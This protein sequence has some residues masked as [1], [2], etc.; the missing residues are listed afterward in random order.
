MKIT[1]LV[2]AADGKGIFQVKNIINTALKELNVE[3]N[4]INLFFNQI[5][6]FD[7]IKSD[8]IR[9]V[10]NSIKDSQGVIIYTNSYFSMIGSLL[11]GFFEHMALAAYND[12][13][14]DKN[15]FIVVNG[16]NGSPIPAMNAISHVIN[17]LGGFDS[18]RLPLDEGFLS[19]L[20][21]EK[22][23]QLIAERS[24]EDFYR[25]LKQQ[26]KYYIPVEG[27]KQ[28]PFSGY[29]KEPAYKNQPV[30][31]EE[32]LWE[33]IEDSPKQVEI[34][35]APKEEP[36][37]TEEAV[38]AQTVPKKDKLLKEVKEDTGDAILHIINDDKFDEKQ[39]KDIE[40]ITKLFSEKFKSNE[41]NPATQDKIEPILPNL[42]E[43]VGKK[44]ILQ[45]SQSL[46]HYFKGTKASD[47]EARVQI[48]IE[49]TEDFKGLYIIENGN[50][51]FKKGEDGSPDITIIAEGLVWEEILKGKI[52]AQKA[53]M[54][55]RIK[56]R[57]NFVLLSKFD[58][59]FEFAME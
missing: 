53:F 29:E 11:E 50:C 43:A 16:K 42:P 5:P 55:G 7:G 46:I 48:V 52:S 51:D 41:T 23:K 28:E 39:I 9:S 2:A 30:K 18:I 54:T 13:L 37:E 33:V 24:A 47:I 26:R 4:E 44:T 31:K 21:F 20:S 8:N 59:S 58:Q 6:C 38:L 32:T 56:V 34:V 49:G 36:K 57:G 40:E 22:D 3:V 14:K 10:V 12:I 15:C 27:M 1:S 25:I 19:A 17:D 35:P 45:M